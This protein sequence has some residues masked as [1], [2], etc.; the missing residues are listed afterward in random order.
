MAL[1]EQP[2]GLDF[3]EGFS[4]IKFQN[5]F[6]LISQNKPD[7]FIVLDAINFDRISRKDAS[8]I[9]QYLI[10]S[11]VKT[12]IID[13]HEQIDKDASDVYLY[14]GS[15]AAVQD[16]Y[17]ICFNYLKLAK[18]KGYGETTM[19]GL[20]SDSG[21]FTYTN[22]RYKEMFELVHSLIESGVSL[23]KTKNLLSDYSSEH[24][25]V[26]SEFMKNITAGDGYSYSYLG[27]DFVATWAQSGKSPVQLNTAAGI[28]ANEYVRN[29]DGRPWGFV[30]YRNLV[31]GDNAYSVS[32]RSQ[33]GAKDV[34]K[35]AN[36]LGG[37]GHIPAAGARVIAKDV[38]AVI[39]KVKKAITTS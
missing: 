1:E 25:F 28:F 36:S 26:L 39:E 32:F 10:D 7:L 2:D 33:S 37:G 17:E 23:E 18:P 30:A 20:F 14:Q 4:D 38:R 27:D 24:M 8:S 15:I 21:G 16:V 6:S 3:L 29:I 35:I 22:T 19:A 5:I 12:A 34:S 31:A 11:N 9:R 13:H